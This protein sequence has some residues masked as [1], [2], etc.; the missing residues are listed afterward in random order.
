MFQIPKE[1]FGT[2]FVPF[3]RVSDYFVFSDI[4]EELGL[5]I[6][7]RRSFTVSE[8]ESIVDFCEIEEKYISR[9]DIVCNKTSNMSAK[10]H[11]ILEVGRD[12]VSYCDSSQTDHVGFLRNIFSIL[13]FYRQRNTAILEDEMREKAQSCLLVEINRKY[14]AEIGIAAQDI[15]YVIDWFGGVER[16]LA[17]EDIKKLQLMVK[18]CFRMD[19]RDFFRECAE[20]F[21][22]S[23]KV[24][25]IFLIIS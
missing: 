14:G 20:V 21:P 6:V 12:L 18:T 13:Y 15:A 17:P 19:R 7:P 8:L 9:M 24:L 23:P 2:A 11:E 3:L 25:R 4:A 5:Y 1:V 16:R 10:G 22:L